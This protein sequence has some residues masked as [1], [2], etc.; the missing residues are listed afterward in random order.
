M[1][2]AAVP[3]EGVT[4]AAVAKAMRKTRDATLVGSYVWKGHNTIFSIWSFPGSKGST[5]THQLPPPNEDVEVVGDLV[6]TAVGDESAET[7]VDYYT[8]VQ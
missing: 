8:E 2:T 6:V 5:N 7:W 1:K 3:T 4:G